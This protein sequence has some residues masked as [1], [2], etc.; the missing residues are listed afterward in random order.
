[1]VVEMEPSSEVVVKPQVSIIGAAAVNIGS[2]DD[3]AA[4]FGARITI[5]SIKNIGA[6]Y[7]LQV[8]GDI[9]DRPGLHNSGRVVHIVDTAKK[10]LKQRVQFH[11]EFS[12]QVVFPEY[13]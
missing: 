7:H 10:Y 8:L 2:R 4:E 3:K 5:V 1:M 9:P 13:K 11:L 6:D 12:A